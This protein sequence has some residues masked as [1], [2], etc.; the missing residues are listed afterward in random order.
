MDINAGPTP[1]YNVPTKAE[2]IDRDRNSN[3]WMPLN[4]FLV[5]H[6]DSHKLTKAQRGIIACLAEWEGVE[7]KVLLSSMDYL[8]VFAKGPALLDGRCHFQVGKRGA[9]KGN[10]HALFMDDRKVRCGLGEIRDHV[11]ERE[12]VRELNRRLADFE[13][14]QAERA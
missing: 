6:F 7:I 9:V 5:A 3:D 4:A 1:D 14:R 2:A 8:L 12:S 11:R 10:L 13:R